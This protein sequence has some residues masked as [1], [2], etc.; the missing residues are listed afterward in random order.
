MWSTVEDAELTRLWPSHSAS[1][2]AAKLGKTRSAVIGRMHRINGTYVGRSYRYK[3]ERSERAA[4]RR[5]VA[6]KRETL[7]MATMEKNVAR[8]TPRNR[9]IKLAFDGG[10]RLK[11]IGAFFGITRQAV[12]VVVRGQSEK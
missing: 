9:A 2:I 1:E 6:V 8:G 5:R 3:T 11:V 4:E 12:S 7:A 10:A